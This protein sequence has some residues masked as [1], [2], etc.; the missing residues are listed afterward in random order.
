MT[1]QSFASF[2]DET[3]AMDAAVTQY[4]TGE[5]A[6]PVVA[7]DGKKFYVCSKATAKAKDWKM[8]T[9]LFTRP[10]KAG[11]EGVKAA[12]K[13]A[14]TTKAKPETA[15]DAAEF[16]EKLGKHAAKR[17]ERKAK[18]DTMKAIEKAAK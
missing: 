18:L 1:K 11:V 9:K 8:L 13:A 3:K 2:N 16:F 15:P 5:R 14:A 6:R 7:T 10:S 17:T 4:A 12:T